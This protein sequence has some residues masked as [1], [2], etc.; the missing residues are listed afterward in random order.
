MKAAKVY[1]QLQ[2]AGRTDCPILASR[3]VGTVCELIVRA[4]EVASQLEDSG[5]DETYTDFVAAELVLSALTMMA[6]HGITINLETAAHAA[7]NLRIYAPPAPAL[8]LQI[9]RIVAATLFHLRSKD[10]PAAGFW[11]SYL[12]GVALEIGQRSAR[13]FYTRAAALE[14]EAAQ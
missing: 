10:L 4:Q 12:I 3:R 2:R 14:T 13:A 8:V 1:R 9:T 11:L 5:D 7:R 6:N